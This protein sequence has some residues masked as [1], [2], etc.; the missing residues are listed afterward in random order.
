MAS[1]V[2]FPREYTLGQFF[3]RDS[4]SFPAEVDGQRLTCLVTIEALQA[5][6]G[7]GDPQDREQAE[8]AFLIHQDE[9][10][11]VARTLIERGLIQNGEVIVRAR[12]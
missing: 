1:T 6:Y 9:I 10:R 7:L 8:Q 12:L 3:D 4:I 2:S 5:R 11:S